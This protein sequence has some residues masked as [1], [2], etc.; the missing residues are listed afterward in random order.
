MAVWVVAILLRVSFAPFAFETDQLL[1]HGTKLRPQAKRLQLTEE[2][3]LW[4]EMCCEYPS[5]EIRKL[6]CVI[7]LTVSVNIPC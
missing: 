5:Q 1:P 7:L 4:K 6:F 3:Q 2:M